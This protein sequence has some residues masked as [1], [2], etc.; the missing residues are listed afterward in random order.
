MEKRLVLFI[1]LSFL[2]LYIHSLFFTKKKIEQVKSP[3]V[4]E[5]VV[6]E[7]KS[8]R[9]KE[10]K[11]A[12]FKNSLFSA[13]LSQK[14]TIKSL[15]LLKF[16]DRK[17]FPYTIIKDNDTFSIFVDNNEIFP[18]EFL[19]NSFVYDLQSF[20][21]IKRYEFSSNTY[22]FTINLSFINKENKAI[23]IPETFISLKSFLGNDPELH[24]NP[25]LYR[26]SSG[27]KKTKNAT[28]N[29]PIDW[30]ATQD[31]Y[32]LFV[33]KPQ[34]RFSSI[35]LSR[36]D[37]K[38][39]FPKYSLKA[40][41]VIENKMMVYAGPRDYKIL[42]G[43]GLESLSGLWFLPKIILFALVFLYKIIGNYGLAI[44][45]LTIIIKIILH[46][47]TRKN[48]KMMK[49]MQAIKPH[50]DKLREKHKDDHETIQK[51]MM[52]LYKEHNVN[53]F[54]G[55]LPLI[56]QMPVFFALYGAL[57]KGIELRCAPFILWIK[58]LSLKDPYFVLPILMGI[59][60][61]IQQKMTPAQ[62]PNTEKMMLIMPIV[63]TFL[64]LNFP[65]GLVLY[66]LVQNILT[67]IEHWLIE[68]G[69]EK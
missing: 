54:G 60:M 16:N 59:T 39:F 3:P 32:F 36:E 56:L 63:M 37:V 44:I 21:I 19:K 8:K 51:E 20:K 31:K 2:I 47:L 7:Q 57:D 33:V 15:N 9:I 14:G 48:F 4:K 61:F 55:C 18:K 53:P 38:A 49:K 41:E 24:E 50:I 64:F 62:D 26:S 34:M 27:I 66:W 69:I 68:K 52:K 43:V 28:L 17:G 42:K 25:F 1:I 58:D 65:S 29:E 45:L 5:E 12:D 46:P 11:G 13:I 10:K 67:I 30:V 23:T 40:N 22:P 6:I 35:S